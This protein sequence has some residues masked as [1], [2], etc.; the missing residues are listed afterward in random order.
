MLEHPADY[1]S[2]VI[3]ARRHLHTRM[4]VKVASVGLPLFLE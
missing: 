2:V 4:A 3:G 1:D